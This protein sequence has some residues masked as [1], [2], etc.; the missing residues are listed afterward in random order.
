MATGVI[1]LATKQIPSHVEYMSFFY[2]LPEIVIRQIGHVFGGE[3]F[4]LGEYS[5]KNGV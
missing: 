3:Y 4:F 5:S 1:V 2:F